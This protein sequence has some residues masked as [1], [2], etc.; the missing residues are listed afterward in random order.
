[1]SVDPD[2]TP[3][4]AAEGARTWSGLA[5][6]CAALFERFGAWSNDGA[7][8]S[9]ARE[10]ASL[11]R[12]LGEHV[13]WWQGLVPDSLLLAD[14]VLDGPVDPGVAML[15]EALAAVPP[16]GRLAAAAAVADVLDADLALLAGRLG[17]VGDAPARRIIRLVRADL[18]DRPAGGSPLDGQAPG[19]QGALAAARP[20]TG[21]T[22][23]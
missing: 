19:L 16:G 20:I 3:V 8:P 11:S 2:P 22:A 1:M 13:A 7:D 4:T 15:V 5:W 9:S 12:R 17:T 18:E 23:G 6:F 10:L 21:E 14:E